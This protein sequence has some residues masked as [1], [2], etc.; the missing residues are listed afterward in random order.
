[1]PAAI[2]QALGEL[3]CPHFPR[4]PFGLRVCAEPEVVHWQEIVVVHDSDQESRAGVAYLVLL[5]I[6]IT[7]LLVDPGT[8]VDDALSVGR[9][10]GNRFPAAVLDHQGLDLLVPEHRADAAPPGL[11]EARALAAHVVPTEVEAAEEGMV[12]AASRR[13]S[14][15]VALLPVGFGEH[16]HHLF[17]DEMGVH[18]FFGRFLDGYLTRVPINKDDHVFLGFAL[19]LEC[20]PPC[21]LEQR[22]KV[23]AHVAIYHRVSHG[24]NANHQRFA[25]A[26]VLGGPADGARSDDDLVLRVVPFGVARDPIPQQP[27]AKALA[28]GEDV[29]HLLGHRLAGDGVV[30][31]VDVESAVG[32][33]LLDLSQRVVELGQHLVGLLHPLDIFCAHN[34]SPLM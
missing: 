23:A 32:V 25:R 14:G 16:L 28:A 15:E 31:E 6:V 18:I 26:G 13:D 9:I 17:A 27:Q 29:L 21:E 20:V 30:G 33:A 10:V 24:R 1:M 19:D 34:S 8:H 2:G 12:S 7:D 22:A 3:A 4:Q 11:L 5:R